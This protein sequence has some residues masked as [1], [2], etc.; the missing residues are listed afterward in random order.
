MLVRAVRRYMLPVFSQNNK[1][2][3]PNPPMYNQQLVV[4]YYNA[5]RGWTD[6]I[7]PGQTLLSIRYGNP[8]SVAVTQHKVHEYVLSQIWDAHLQAEN[9]STIDSL[10]NKYL[11]QDAR[12]IMA[13]HYFSDIMMKEM[14]CSPFSKLQ[15]KLVFIYPEPFAGKPATEIKTDT[16]Q[17]LFP[18]M[19]FS[20]N[21]VAAYK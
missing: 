2:F 16:T 5:Q 11:L 10:Q 3:A 19:N 14:R 20:P 4:R 8:F 13:Q 7:N 21:Y 17:L 18:E 15:Y 1:V 6:W 9:K 12:C